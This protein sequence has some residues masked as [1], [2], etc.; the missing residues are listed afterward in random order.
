MCFVREW[1][2][3]FLHIAITPWL[4]SF[5]QVGCFW[6]NPKSFSNERN[7]IASCNAKFAATYSASIEDRAI[8]GCF[9][10]PG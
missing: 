9:Y 7:H 8:I 5:M 1:N 10:L 2:F 3:G 4:S 6:V